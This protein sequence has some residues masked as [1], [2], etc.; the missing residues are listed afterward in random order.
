MKKI[1][2]ICMLLLTTHFV[3]AAEDECPPA[4]EMAE[5]QNHNAY[6]NCDYSDKGL[7]GVLHRALAKKG[8]SGEVTKEEKEAK[9]ESTKAVEK[10]QKNSDKT[11]SLK[12]DEFASPQ[13]LQ[14]VKFVLLE[15]L[16]SE[17]TKGFVVE[18]ERYLPVTNSKAMKLQLIYHCL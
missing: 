17:C 4:A 13:Q 6:K 1:I 11:V 2:T 5:A 10:A 8:E 7:N 12:D 15:R 16:A 18:G 3:Y 14:S 9:N